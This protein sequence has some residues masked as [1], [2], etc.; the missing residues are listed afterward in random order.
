MA[1]L[2]PVLDAEAAIERLG[3]GARFVDG[4]WRLYE[5]AGPALEAFA[6]QRIPGAVYFDIDAVADPASDLP[7]MLPAPD[8]FADAVS[9]LGLDPS[10]EIIVY[11]QD[12]TMAA[13]RVWWMLKAMGAPTVSVLNDGLPAWRAAE[14][15]IEQNAPSPKAAPRFA[16]AL[17]RERLATLPDVVEAVRSG[18]PLIVDARPADRFEGRAPEPRPGLRSGAM[19][20]AA[21]LPAADLLDHG[22]LPD[23]TETARR[24]RA[25]GWAPDRSAITTCGSGVAASLVALAIEHAGGAPA[26]VYD[27]SWAEWG[28]GVDSAGRPLPIVAASA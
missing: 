11:D 14:G 12:G 23:P 16:A 26:A 3:T 18:A 7:H 5:G 9:A 28:R 2:N 4:T 21:N 6:S 10:A 27:G 17:A 1:R 15:P 20:G 13:A 19:P 8:P 22:R 25:V 24:L